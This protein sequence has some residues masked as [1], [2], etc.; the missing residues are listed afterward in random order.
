[1]KIGIMKKTLI[2]CCLSFAITALTSC[3][4][5]E[6][7]PKKEEEV[8]KD[9]PVKLPV[10][11]TT[12]QPGLSANPVYRDGLSIIAKNDC[13]TCHKI[14]E[15]LVGPSYRDIANKYGNSKQSMVNYL[16]DKIIKGGTG[17]WGQ[18][19]ML[20]HAALSRQDAEAMAKYILLLKNQDK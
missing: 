4:T 17:V 19:P 1:M 9:E 3:K 8:R 2:I 12:S 7:E 13:L 5:K 16:V 6:E 20:P 14:D 15:K 10:T 11:D 18:V